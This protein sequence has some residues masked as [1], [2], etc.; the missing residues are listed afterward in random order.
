[1]SGEGIITRLADAGCLI[2]LSDLAR[3]STIVGVIPLALSADV[4]AAIVV[5]YKMVVIASKASSSKARLALFD[6]A[7]EEGEFGEEK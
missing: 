4:L 2:E 1:M 3:G 5:V 6:S 7:G